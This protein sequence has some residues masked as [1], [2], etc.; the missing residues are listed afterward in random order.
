MDRSVSAALLKYI[1]GAALLLACAAHVRAADEPQLDPALPYQAEASNPVA[2]D[3]DFSVVVTPPYHA[4]LLRVWIPVPQSDK[5]QEYTEGAWNT[6]PMA[7]EPKVGSEKVFGN[8][9]AYFEFKDPQGAQIIRHT[10]KIKAYELH[11]NIEVDKVTQPKVWPDSFQP[12]LRSESQAVVADDRF[13]QL[14]NTIVPQRD[15]N[16]LKNFSTVM[17]WVIKDFK[18]NHD[19]A[20]LHA[21]SVW[22]IEKHEGHCSD[23]HGFCSAMGR[24]LSSPTR[25]T[26]GINP[27]P[28][29]SPSH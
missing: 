29:N 8:T 23:Y 13:N 20:S 17:D 15:A 10:F 28:K 26:Y 24:V 21:S 12:Y 2:Y 18:Y 1:C 9:F 6:F 19:D 22:A 5:G 11:W 27:F 25:M 3:V 7:V 14:V 4:K 16:P